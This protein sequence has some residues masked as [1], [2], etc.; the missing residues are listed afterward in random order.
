M[1]NCRLT[2]HRSSKRTGA[3]LKCLII[4]AG[5]GNTGKSGTLAK[6]GDLL[7]SESS[8]FYEHKNQT[9]SRDRQIVIYYKRANI[10][11]GTAGDSKRLVRDNIQFFKLQKCRIGI[12]AANISGAVQLDAHI[13]KWAKKKGVK[14]ATIH[15]PDFDTE[16]GREAIQ[17]ACIE[18]IKRSLFNCSPIGKIV[19]AIIAED[20]AIT[21][22]R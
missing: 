3:V 18:A 5:K 12:L 1:R 13:Q 15:K 20:A 21:K 11:I 22:L 7:R 4:L 6:L 2:P 16:L 9:N 19:K 8:S 17:V 14:C 10:G